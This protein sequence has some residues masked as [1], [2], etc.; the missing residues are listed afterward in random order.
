MHKVLFRRPFG[1][2]L[3]RRA[4]R[5]SAYP[6][7]LFHWDVPKAVW[8]SCDD[9]LVVMSSLTYLAVER[10]FLGLWWARSILKRF[11]DLVAAVYYVLTRLKDLSNFLI[12]RP[13]DQKIN[14]K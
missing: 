12:G 10:V 6:T 14:G 1:N 3:R 9:V 5:N 11:V 7:D 2:S 4:F 8:R 13:Y